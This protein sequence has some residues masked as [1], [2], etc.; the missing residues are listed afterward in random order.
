M[1]IHQTHLKSFSNVMYFVAVLAILQL[2]IGLIPLPDH[3]NHVDHYLVWHSSM[4]MVSIVICV[5]VFVIGWNAK[6][7]NLPNGLF[8]LS[9]IFLCIGLFDALHTFSYLG[10]PDFFSHNDSQKHLSFWMS[11]RLFAAFGLLLVVASQWRVNVSI[12]NKY[13]VLLAFLLVTF[14][15]FWIVINH[16][17]WMPDWFIDGVGLTSLKK[18]IEYVIIAAH[19]ITAFLIFRQLNQASKWASPMLLGAVLVMALSE[20]FFTWYTTMVGTYNV[21]GHVYKVIAYYMIYRAIV[22]QALEMPYT[23]L[24]KSKETLDLALTSS[25]TGLWRWKI[26]SPN[27][28]L[29]PVLKQ[30]IGYADDEF[31]NEYSAFIKLVH[32]HDRQALQDNLTAYIANGQLEGFQNEFRLRHKNGSYRWIYSQG[33]RI[34]SESDGADELIGIHTD[35]TERKLEEERFRAALQAAPNAM[36]MVDVHGV[37][38][39][40]NSRADVLFDYKNKELIG[41]PISVLIPD[42][43]AAAHS[44]HFAKYMTQPETRQMGEGRFLSAKRSSGEEF[45]VEIGL[46]VIHTSDG[47]YILASIVDLT[48]KIK[49]EEHIHKLMHYDGLTGLP[50]RH[51]L[52]TLGDAFVSRARTNKIKVGVLYI[53]L[54]GFK[55][56]NDSFGHLVGDKVLVEVV[57]RLNS[58]TKSSDIVARIVGD[59]FVVMVETTSE[60]K[61]AKLARHIN[62]VIAEPIMVTADSIL[63]TSSV[64]VAI[65]PDD[66]TEFSQIL[67]HA[68]TAMSMLKQSGRN[69][70]L[71][72]SSDMQSKTSR[73][74]IIDKAL[75][76]AIQK[77]QFYLHY[78]PQVCIKNQQIIGV[79]ALLRWYHPELGQVSPAEF[80]P[81]AE[82]NGLIIPI[83]EWVLREALT[84]LKQWIDKG[85]KPIIMAVNLSAVQF[86]NENLV[87]MVTKVLQDIQLPPD[88]LELELT[89]SIAMENPASV[90]KVLEE[91]SNH[92]IKL[93]IDDFGTGYSSLSYLKKFK[94]HKLKIDQSFIREIEEDRDDRSIVVTIIQMA[95]NLGYKTIAEG[96]ETS[97]QLD[98][99][100]ERGCDE[101]QGYA[102]SRPIPSDEL[103]EN[104]LTQHH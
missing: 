11:A 71:F 13:L 68:N 92:G 58:V 7:H 17:H 75:R 30:Q 49:S 38:V 24:E 89:E 73:S 4:E 52:K 28:Y 91:L 76:S 18:N 25:N 83:G 37:I 8:M 63:I 99:L 57:K 41:K 23:K 62:S 59:E 31:S 97:V 15:I 103:E 29:S 36:L 40:S 20:I 85:Y 72:F 67:Q 35:I 61:I 51:L 44:V 43:Y 70:Y 80:I 66:G 74:L 82:A 87:H 100:K 86:R 96:V 33:K 45:R 1:L 16:Q 55:Y 50:N 39:L 65:F 12:L 21:M 77:N 42:E 47:Q 10:M 81:H 22:L 64:G 5:M 88:Y 79:E 2:F 93:A 9:I 98:F 104:F 3:L 27:L 54:D 32:P 60:A 53:G 6:N 69:D 95:K 90:I 101:Y 48:E 94:V 26:G 14:S 78:Q 34:A 46:T 84:Q 19:L 102:F 56:L